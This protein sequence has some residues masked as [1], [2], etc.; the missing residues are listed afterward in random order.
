LVSPLNSS[1]TTS[2]PSPVA[3]TPASAPAAAPV[4]AKPTA[5]AGSAAL[6]AT[7]AP[8]P[9]LGAA[10]ASGAPCP[11]PLLGAAD[12]QS[13][14]MCRQMLSAIVTL[15]QQFMKDMVAGNTFSLGTAGTA[16][17]TTPK[18]AVTL[19]VASA[20]TA[21]AGTAAASPSAGNGRLTIAQID[22]F[23]GTTHGQEIANVLK[24]GGGDSS[25]AGKVDLIQ[26]DI[27]KNGNT[28]QN[29][30]DA[31]QSVIQQ[32][33]SG[34]KI[35]AVNMSLQ[36]F[37][38]SATSKQTSALVDQLAA[39]GVPVAV[40]AGNSGPGQ[41]NQL[42]GNNSFNVQSATN[43]QINATSGKGNVTANGQTTSFA[44]A[45]LAPVL[46]A[47]HAQGLSVAQIR[48]SV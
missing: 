35:D 34:T 20:G 48:A 44:T 36:D 30:N 16:G 5:T 2:L 31:L 37:Q 14:A 7:S 46:A 11:T 40:A 28:S 9:T 24:N 32:V 38:A 33:Q 27:A 41:V 29:I 43:G 25:L 39:L 22:S 23:T 18:P 42:E 4:T 3:L 15:L 45:N 13:A 6:S 8:C 10:D 21:S 26:F 47:K 17:T 1:L 12:A 19:P